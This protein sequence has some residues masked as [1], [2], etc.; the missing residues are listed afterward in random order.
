MGS[1]DPDLKL[2]EAGVCNYCRGFHD[3]ATQH[4]I[5]DPAELDSLVAGIKSGGRAYDAVLGISGGTDSSYC[6]LT[7]SKLGLRVLLLS[8]QNGYDDPRALRNI[9][10]VSKR[11]GFPLQVLSVNWA[12]YRDLQLAY[13]RSGV[14]DLEV[15]TDHAITALDYGT[16]VKV[17][18]KYLLSGSNVATEAIQPVA[19]GHDKQDLRNLK[20]IHRRFG[21][22]P[23]REFPTLD[24]IGLYRTGVRQVNLLNYVE[25]NREAAKRELASECGWEDYGLKHWENIYTRFYQGYILPTRFGIDKRRSH[26][27]C[28]INTGQMTREEALRELEKPPYADPKQLEQDRRFVLERLGISNEEFEGYMRLP[29]HKHTDFGT[30]AQKYRWLRRG[31]R[32]LRKIL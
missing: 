28:L 11:T 1:S 18:V 7:A 23:L 24:R 31:K 25:Y 21:T 27:S 19:W 17:G 9:D 5:R 14:V 29:F 2:D 10:R 20:A 16:A 12:E 8:L 32:L 22:V 30:D 4:M 26:F 13:L 6:A 3:L 15:P